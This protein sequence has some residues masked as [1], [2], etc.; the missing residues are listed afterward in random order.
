MLEILTCV[1]SAA[2]V[3]LEVALLSLLTRFA[4]LVRTLRLLLVIALVP[5]ASPIVLVGHRTAFHRLSVDQFESDYHVHRD[6]YLGEMTCS[7]AHSLIQM[8]LV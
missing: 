4:V 7:V 8:L 1:A 3:A 6:L 5:Q 2:E